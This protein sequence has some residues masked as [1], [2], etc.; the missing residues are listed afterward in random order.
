[1][2]RR[3][4]AGLDH[5]DRGWQVLVGLAAVSGSVAAQAPASADTVSLE[6]HDALTG[7]RVAQ[8]LVELR[9]TVPVV[10]RRAPFP[11]RRMPGAAPSIIEVV[12]WSPLSSPASATGST[13]R[14]GGP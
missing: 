1:V 13:L 6:L 5:R 9:G 4:A 3:R 7:Q 8:T 12:S 2:I 11:S 10:C 14:R